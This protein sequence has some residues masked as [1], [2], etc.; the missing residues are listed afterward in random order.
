LIVV[1][2]TP[3]DAFS[4]ITR[5]MAQQVLSYLWIPIGLSAFLF[6]SLLVAQRL[7]DR[8]P[9][10]SKSSALDREKL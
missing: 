5:K 4:A 3:H 1:V 10:R 9:R 6:L 2:A 8:R 7:A